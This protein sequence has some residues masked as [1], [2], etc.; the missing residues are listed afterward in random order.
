MKKIPDAVLVRVL[1][2]LGVGHSTI[3]AHASRRDMEE[4]LLME[5]GNPHPAARDTISIDGLQKDASGDR[6]LYV[7][8]HEVATMGDG[9][10]ITPEETFVITQSG[11]IWTRQEIEK[12][13]GTR[14]TVE[15]TITITQSGCIVNWTGIWDVITFCRNAR[16]LMASFHTCLGHSHSFDNAQVLTR[17]PHFWCIEHAPI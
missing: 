16:I 6:G 8:D 12:K 4:R 13:D 5:I 11:Y 2:E 14:K 1:R 7:Q 17:A 10:K 15:E 9:M 3:P